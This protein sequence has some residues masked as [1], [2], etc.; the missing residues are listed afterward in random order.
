MSLRLRIHTVSMRKVTSVVA[1]TVGVLFSPGTARADT[2]RVDR[3]APVVPFPDGSTWDLAFTS[4]QDA[5]DAASDNLGHDTIWVAE[6]Y[7]TRPFS[8][9]T[10]PL[11]PN[12]NQRFVVIGRFSEETM[13]EGGY[14]VVRDANGLMQSVQRDPKLYETILSADKSCA[15][16]CG[17]PAPGGCDTGPWNDSSR[18]HNSYH[19][20][21]AIANPTAGQRSKLILSGLIIEGGSAN[22]DIAFAGCT[23]VDTSARQFAYA[24]GGLAV[25][26]MDLDVADCTFRNNSA[27]MDDSDP[28]LDE[29]V[30]WGGAVA[31]INCSAQDRTAR[32]MNCI[33]HDNTASR[34]GAVAIMGNADA[35]TPT[36]AEF[37]NCLFHDN[38]AIVM[39]NGITPLPDAEGGGGA[40][41]ALN[42][43]RIKLVHCTL[44]G[45]TA[46]SVHRTAQRV[47]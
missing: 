23:A 21:E 24:G 36:I 46:E 28:S 13:I 3:C 34:G 10:D 45:N 1:L 25:N 22:I 18:R 30:G 43:T 47:S 12:R 2:Y 17:D 19:V 5:L 31:F 35:G 6:G 8:E 44:S 42:N 27:G 33:F 14:H 7:Y 15:R 20:I 16:D 39:D 40:I 41:F 38:Q 11:D 4:L 37:T 29:H 9:T 32:F 26:S